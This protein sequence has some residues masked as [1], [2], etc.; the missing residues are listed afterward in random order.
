MRKTISLTLAYALAGAAPLAAQAPESKTRTAAY[1]GSV[2]QQQI[3]DQAR[4]IREELRRLVAEFRD[5]PAAGADIAQA[6]AILTKLTALGDEDMLRVIQDL[7]GASSA[8]S[9]SDAAGKLLSASS[10]QKAV[11]SGLR[12]IADRL[13]RQADEASMEQRIRGLLL[14][15]LTNQGRTHNLLDG[16]TR[17]WEMKNAAIVASAQQ[18]T[19]KT[20]VDLLLQKF[21]ELSADAGANLFARLLA[22][23][24]KSQLGESSSKASQLL[25]EGNF[26]EAAKSQ[27]SVIAAFQNLLEVINAGKTAEERLRTAATQMEELGAR[28]TQLAQA[29][30]RSGGGEQNGTKAEQRAI[31]NEIAAL[32]R[33]VAQLSPK[34]AQDLEKAWNGMGG[35]DEKL[36]TTDYLFNAPNRTNFVEEQRGLAD[37]VKGVADELK[38]QADKMDPAAGTSGQTDPSAQAI[39]EASQSVMEAQ[40][41]MNATTS[42]MNS[43][44]DGQSLEQKLNSARSALAEAKDQIGQAGAAVPS[45]ALDSLASAE[46]NLQGAEDKLGLGKDGAGAGKG[47]GQPDKQ[48]ASNRL[49]EAKR[50]SQRALDALRQAAN[51]LATGQGPNGGRSGQS[52]SAPNQGMGTPGQTENENL[53]LNALDRLPPQ[54]RQALSQLQ[55]EKYPAEYSAMV[56]QYV[57]NLAEGELPFVTG[58]TQP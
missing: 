34:A 37:E 53:G 44:A 22:V 58:A 41:E 31:A 10:A 21:R 20:E 25:A 50:D 1:Q 42:M 27:L 18:E 28:Q 38:G 2:T 7:R 35:L 32:G 19:L 12:T 9:S 30:E 55:R 49:D 4:R 6:E 46:K 29:T 33:E 36:K 13:G 39:A 8:D 47:P 51:D 23:A 3:Q 14:L 17:D 24:G 5:N 57:K 45:A 11:Q 16:T 40:H 52:A 15:Q 43:G 48:G 54:D 26:A 56:E